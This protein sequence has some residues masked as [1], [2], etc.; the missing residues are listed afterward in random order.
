MRFFYLDASALAKRYAR[1]TGTPLLN[2]LFAHAPLDRLIVFN[3]S[4]A[5]VASVLVRKRNAGK[6]PAAAFAQAMINLAG[7]I[8][9]HA[10]VR[11][12]TADNTLVNAAIPLIEQHSV[13][14]T[15]GIILR[16]A[17][18]LAVQLRAAS[19]DLTLVASDQRLLKAAQAEGLS[20]FDPGTQ[21][22]ADLDA[23]L[24]P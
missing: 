9:N 3:V 10:Q 14:S 1:E 17:L 22:Q 19:D 6:V 8:T 5:E 2:H 12:L 13:N 16:S 24:G 20:T 23:L 21:T 18:D 11:K 15:D 7:E 4:I